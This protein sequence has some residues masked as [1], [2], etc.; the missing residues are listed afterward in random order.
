MALVLKDRVQETSTT[1]GTGTLTL[2]G[3]VAGYQSFAAVG[4]GN[5]TYYTITDPTSGA[6]EVGVGTYTASGTTLSRTTVL[7]SSNGGSLVSFTSA[8]K[9]VFCTYPSEKGVWLDASGNVAQTNY[10]SITASSIALTTGTIS[11]TPSNST[12]IANKTYVDNTLNSVNYHAACEYATTA[13]LGSVTY[14][15]GTSGVGAT[16]TNAGTQAALVIDGHTF[17]STDATN[18]TRVLVKNETSGQY[19]GVYTV[20]NQ[21]SGSTNWV[22]TRAT[23]YDQTGTGQNEIAPGDYIFVI[24][25]TSNANTAWIQSTDAPITIGTTPLSFVQVAGTGTYAAGTGLTLTANTFSITNTGVTATTYGSASTVPVITV[26]AQGQITSASSTSIAISGSQ[27]TS[28]T[29][30]TSYISGSYTG[31][32]GVGTLTAG[33]WN[34]TAIVT[35]Y[36]GTGINSY[37]AGDIIYYA[38]GTALSKLAIGSA[39]YV[40]TSSGTAPQYVAQ[41]TLSV[42][43]ASTA[44]NIASGAANQIHYQ[45]AAST[46]AFITA[47]SSSGTVLNWNGSAFNWVNGTI[48]G[49]SLGSNLNALT[50]GTGLSG[51]SY[52]GSSGVTIAN[53]GVTSNAAGTGISVSGST[54]AVTI[55]NTGVTSNAAGTGISVSGSTGTVTI[56]NSGVTSAVAGTGVSVSGSTGAVT[57]SIGQS[58]A[59]SASPTFSSINLTTATITPNTS[60]VSTGLNVVN[61]D[62]TTYRSGGTTGVIYFGSSGNKYLYY[63]GTNYNMP[64]GALYVNSNNV[65][66]AGNYTSYSP[67]LTGSGASGTWGINISGNASNIT[68]YTINQSVGTGNAP[69]FSG[70]TVSSTLNITGTN[71]LYWN[72]YGRGIDVADASYSYGN[73]GT[74]GGGLNGW[75]GYGVYSNNTI[76]MGNGSNWGFYNP[77]GGFWMYYSDQSGNTTF[78]GNVT[79]YSDIRLKENIREIDDVIKRRDNLAKSA[80]KY[81][82]DG[83]TRVGYAA[84]WLQED[85]PEFVMEADDS[86]KLVTGLGTLSVDYGETAA[87]LAVASKMTDDR[88]AA[89]ETR[90]VQLEKLLE[91]KFK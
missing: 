49:V 68:S 35:T 14:N 20:T 66:T 82:R 54:G 43:S 50:I 2:G 15:N 76:L 53:T 74:Y 56:T 83:R 12:D 23:D 18:K 41:S 86:L 3:A 89:L 37:T 67:S 73:I 70:L 69:S 45:S 11:T 30:G 64:G 32:T 61:G 8:A 36:G 79:A 34:G 91:E 33:V 51:T 26:N 80:I 31:I 60:G 1:S 71:V 27:I 77:S 55:T 38:S 52:N 75:Q 7:A 16:I 65:L 57:F 29:V 19:N 5:T 90:I 62:I 4:D 9:S 13:D 21:G 17:T 88:V 78:Y 85:N 22:L 84:Q 81:E 47:P 87:V 48:S 44:T 6:W 28:G 46:T 58:V 24:A 39:N 40:L 72:S 42:G 63:D 25:G 10:N 59:T